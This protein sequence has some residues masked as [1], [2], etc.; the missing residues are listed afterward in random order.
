MGIY[1]FLN[2]TFGYKMSAKST[3]KDKKKKKTV[4]LFRYFEII[5]NVIL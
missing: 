1:I 4:V 5:M 2:F 3:R